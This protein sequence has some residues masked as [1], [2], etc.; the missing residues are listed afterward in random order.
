MDREVFKYRKTV[1][2]GAV[3][4][5]ATLVAYLVF[6]LQSE[7]DKIVLG[8]LSLILLVWIYYVMGFGAILDRHYE[9][10]TDV[11]RIHKIWR[12]VEDI[13]YD[14]IRRVTIRDSVEAGP[15]M[16]I[17]LDAKTVRIS[18]SDLDKEFELMRMLEEKGVAHGFNI[19]HQDVKGNII[20]SLNR[21]RQHKKV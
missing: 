15:A 8:A 21:R 12:K 16:T 11:L 17:M 18:V 10:E 20:K 7:G 3:L 4:H 9:F 6:V 1:W 2:I 19:V 14:Q 5:I 13:R